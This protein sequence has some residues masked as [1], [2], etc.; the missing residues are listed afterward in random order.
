MAG[1]NSDIG[2]VNG[3]RHFRL[4]ERAAGFGYWRTT[5][6]DGKM[7]WSEGLYRM[8]GIEPGSVEPG[9]MWLTA[10]M[11]PADI[12]PTLQAIH[13]AVQTQQPFYIRTRTNDPD[14]PVQ[15]V[16]TYGEVELDETGDVIA[17][18]A[19]CKD[20]TA[21]VASEQAKDTA[22]QRYSVMAE[23]SSDIIV[24]HE[25]GEAVWASNALWRLLGRTTDEMRG[26][27]YLALVHPDDLEEA[28]KISGQPPPGATWTAT[29]R[30]RH[31]D[32]HYVWF[33]VSTRSVYDEN[34]GA[35]RREIS[36]GRDVTE[37]K[38]QEIA[39]R[40]AQE[41][42]EA[43]NRAKSQFLA[44][45]S[46]EL[47]T[48]LNAII[49]FADIMRHRM[50]GD[51]K[52]GRY[53]EYVQMIHDSAQLLLTHI[54]GILEMA[55]I[56]GGKLTLDVEPLALSRI[57]EEAAR[58]MRDRAQENGV[59]LSLDCTANLSLRADAHAVRQILLHLLSNALKFTQPGGHVRLAAK[60]IG[61]KTVLSVTDDGFGIPANDIPRLGR[62]FEQLV[63]DPMVAKGTTGTGLGLALVRSLVERHGGALKI[64]SELGHGTTVTVEFPDHAESS[65]A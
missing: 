13:T 58:P 33:E 46:H 50:L 12:A 38:R 10:H 53:D 49:G 26:D 44:N 54:A 52:D 29:Y 59:T 31:A 43:A 14:A 6:A 39:M 11:D 60:R 20:V 45:M 32:G 23:E 18:A 19:V 3:W 4:A 42:A 7:F 64:E 65:A 55:N 28:H 63:A 35:F 5:F 9:M 16:D 22:Q 48:P 30:V 21:Q 47:R 51:P 17:V 2:G 15:F 56:E 8:M 24:L 40:A 27:K 61:T 34:T 36:V 25:N 1:D 62:P 41:R 57:L 37:R